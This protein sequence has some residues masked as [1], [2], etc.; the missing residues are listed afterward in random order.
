MV[1]A[2][3]YTEPN[4][5][6]TLEFFKSGLLLSLKWGRSCSLS[7]NLSKEF[8]LTSEFLVKGVG[9][10]MTL[11]QLFFLLSVITRSVSVL[12]L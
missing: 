12:L 3:D 9:G 8:E 4:S 11:I 10:G 5:Y 1:N 7:D 2:N 6:F